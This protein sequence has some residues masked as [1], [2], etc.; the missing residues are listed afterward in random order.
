MRKL[1]FRMTILL[2]GWWVYNFYQPDENSGDE[3][4]PNI[5]EIPRIRREQK[6]EI[7]QITDTVERR[8][9]LPR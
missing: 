2:I 5:R 1:I 8:E 9:E 3:F 7:Y 6:V 4:R